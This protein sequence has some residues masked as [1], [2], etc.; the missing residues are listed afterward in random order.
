MEYFGHTGLG[1]WSEQ[2]T[3]FAN[4][5]N[6]DQPAVRRRSIYDP[7]CAQDASRSGQG[8]QDIKTGFD[9]DTRDYQCCH[10][11]STV[12]LHTHLPEH[13][14]LTTK[15]GLNKAFHSL[16]LRCGIDWKW[17]WQFGMTGNHE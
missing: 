17:A 14:P 8:G 16:L 15:K 2:L 10:N 9:P 1:A 13:M 11:A 4:L 7:C 6:D 3:D 5:G 12:R